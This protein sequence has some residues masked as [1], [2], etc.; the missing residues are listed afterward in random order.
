MW[1]VKK[2][3]V[4]NYVSHWAGSIG[5]LVS[6]HPVIIIIRGCMPQP[7]IMPDLVRVGND[8]CAKCDPYPAGVTTGV[9]CAT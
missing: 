2:V 5:V 7:E 8:V 4:G 6:N 1:S 3:R 9:I